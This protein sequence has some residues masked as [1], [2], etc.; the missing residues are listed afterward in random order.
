MASKSIGKGK[1]MGG[2]PDSVKVNMP[3]PL[4]QAMGGMTPAGMKGTATGNP[5]PKIKFNSKGKNGG[6][7]C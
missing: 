6:A 2:V 7:L 4:H 3:N 5:I 1:K